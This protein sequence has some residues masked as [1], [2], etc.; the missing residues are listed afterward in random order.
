MAMMFIDRLYVAHYSQEALTAVASSGTLAWGVI[1]FISSITTMS[2]VFVAQYNGAKKHDAL[3]EP[4]WQTVWFSF[5]S[6]LFFTPV[7][8][9]FTPFLVNSGFFSL[10]EGEYFLWTILFAPAYALLAGVSGFFIGLKT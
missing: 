6:I 7:A 10:M 9:L 2:E 5:A 1:L 4:V 8:L 3:G